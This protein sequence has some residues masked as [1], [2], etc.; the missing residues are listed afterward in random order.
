MQIQRRFTRWQ[1]NQQ[2]KIKLEGAQNYINCKVN[3]L[4]FQGMGFSL[5]LKLPRDTFIRFSLFLCEEFIFDIIEAWVVWH[6]VVDHHNAYGLYFTQIKDLDK[7]KIYRFLFKYFPD[8]VKAKYWEYPSE[9]KGGE[10]ME[11]RRIFQRFTAGFS[12]R[13]LDPKSGKEGVAKTQDISAKGLGLVTNEEFRAQAPLEVWLSIP[14][15][16]EPLY[17]RGTVVWSKPD[18]QGEYRA[19]IDLEKADLMGLSRVLRTI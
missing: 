6:K 9:E 10:E 7:E 15:K 3:D 18:T 11:D 17:T 5:P 2:A 1:I 8:Q 12:L 13:F 19:G 4:S 16:G 14:D